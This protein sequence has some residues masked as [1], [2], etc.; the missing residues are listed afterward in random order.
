MTTVDAILGRVRE[1]QPL[2]GTV[3]KLITVVNDP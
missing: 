1:I 2:P 3:L